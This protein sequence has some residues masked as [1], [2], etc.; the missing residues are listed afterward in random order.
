MGLISSI[1]RLLDSGK[2][3]NLSRNKTDTEH[4]E[5][6]KLIHGDIDAMLYV[7]DIDMV[8]VVAN[9]YLW[10]V[11]RDGYLVDTLRGTSHLYD[12][13]IIYDTDYRPINPDD[14]IGNTSI[15]DWIYTGDRMPKKAQAVSS[16]KL[17]SNNELYAHFD[18]ADVVDFFSHNTSSGVE[19]SIAMVKFGNE[20]SAIELPNGIG[21]VDEESRKFKNMGN[22]I[23]QGTCLDGYKSKYTTK[24]DSLNKV[25]G[26]E[27]DS[28]DKN[29]FILINKFIRQHYY[30][31]EGF[32]WWLGSRLLKLFGVPGGLPS[33]FL[34]RLRS[35]S[36][37]PQIRTA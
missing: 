12:T 17:R 8:I 3:Q 36:I 4:Y 14:V 34:V 19:K 9:G 23:Y 1:K 5:I 33:F 28:K 30:F 26:L 29:K 18:K 7:K 15:V 24:L 20:W 32:F 2:Y 22:I 11:D 16:D 10:K 27:M 21:E 31:E 37:K 6:R 25:I 35:Y 13:G